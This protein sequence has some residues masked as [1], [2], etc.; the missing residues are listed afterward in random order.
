MFHVKQRPKVT[1]RGGAVKPCKIRQ[2]VAGSDQGTRG[3][4]LVTGG[5]SFLVE[6]INAVARAVFL[7][8][9]RV[10]P[11]L[12]PGAGRRGGGW[13]G[14][15]PGIWAGA[16]AYSARIAVWRWRGVNDGAAALDHGGG[17]SFS[18]IL[19]CAGGGGRSARRHENGGGLF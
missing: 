5:A 15:F 17:A 4:D 19:G 10:R 16:A 11:G 13:L 2:P 18:G 14:L 9:G 7:T 3:G 6:K 8:A 12:A 1:P